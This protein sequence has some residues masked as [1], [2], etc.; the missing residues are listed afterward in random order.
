MRLSTGRFDHVFTQLSCAHPFKLLSPRSEEDSVVNIYVPLYGGG[1]VGGDEVEFKVVV[2]E[3]A[4]LMLSTQVPSSSFPPCGLARMFG[5]FSSIQFI[6]VGFHKSVQGQVHKPALTF[7]DKQH[8]LTQPPCTSLKRRC[9][10][11]PPGPGNLLQTH[12]IRP[13][14]DL[15]SRRW[16]VTHRPRF[17]HVGTKVS[18]SSGDSTGS[19]TCG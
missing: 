12:L 8:Y 5:D 6:L 9:V 19:T 4:S 17:F 2:G 15:P 16:R 14:Q 13:T 1:L 18:W 10:L 11:P 7:R 3:A